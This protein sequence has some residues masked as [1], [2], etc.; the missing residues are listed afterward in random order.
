ML[1]TDTNQQQIRALLLSN[2]L[3]KTVFKPMINQCIN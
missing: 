1:L 2:G 3:K